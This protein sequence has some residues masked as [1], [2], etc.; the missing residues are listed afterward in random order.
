MCF[1]LLRL[2]PHVTSQKMHLSKKKGPWLNYLSQHE[3]QYNTNS[4]QEEEA[5]QDKL[6]SLLVLNLDELNRLKGKRMRERSNEEDTA[7]LEDQ[8]YP[9]DA[10]ADE[11]A[12]NEVAHPHQ[13]ELED[14]NHKGRWESKGFEA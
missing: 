14:C 12:L 11:G 10:Q 3:Q 6:E 2:N 13:A 9:G 1:A 8:V 7:H 4:D 5:L